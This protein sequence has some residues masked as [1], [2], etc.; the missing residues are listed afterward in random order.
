MN[1]IKAIV[2]TLGLLFDSSLLQSC[3]SSSGKAH[4]GVNVHY[5]QG[6][7]HG[8]YHHKRYNHRGYYHHRPSVRHHGRAGHRRPH[9]R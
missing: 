8:Y 7:G 1:G 9:R 5:R 6:W 4:Y 2:I 3:A